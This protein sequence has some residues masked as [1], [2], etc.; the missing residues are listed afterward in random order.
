MVPLSERMEVLNKERKHSS[1]LA[2]LYDKN[3]SSTGEIVKKEKET[4]ASHAV[5][6]QTAKVTAT[7]PPECLQRKRR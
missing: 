7:G 5:A 1:D 2:K 6:F 3:E 4:C